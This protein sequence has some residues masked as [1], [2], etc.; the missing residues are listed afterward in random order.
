MVDITNQTFGID[1]ILQGKREQ[2]LSIAKA[3]KAYNVRIFGSVARGEATNESDID[4]LVV[5]EEG[6]TLWDHVGLWQALGELLNREVN[7]STD[8]TLRNEFKS[9]VLC[10]AVKL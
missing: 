6:Y 5:F 3:H 4:F 2:V 1:E 8:K 10:E 9:A 7:I